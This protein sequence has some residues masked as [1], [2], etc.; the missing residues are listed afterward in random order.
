MNLTKRNK[1]IIAAVALAGAV[2]VT[3]SAFT[4][5]GLSDS[6]SDSFIG[7]TVDQTITGAVL[8]D[9]DYNIG[10][11]D[12]ID[13]VAVTVTGNVAGR[14]LEIEFYDSVP[15]LTGA[16]YTCTTISGGGTSSCTPT[17][18]KAKSVDVETVTF[19]VDN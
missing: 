18:T 9:V 4:A 12:D 2:A 1:I 13:S 15:A 19:R 6:S 3:G 14:T 8:T 5:G 10:V 17:G 16:A 11:D 7:G